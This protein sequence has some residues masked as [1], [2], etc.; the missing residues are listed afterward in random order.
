MI[1]PKKLSE[2][3]QDLRR[4]LAATQDDPIAWLEE[5]VTAAE[6]QGGS[7]AAKTEVLSSI[8]RILE[9]PRRRRKQVGV[10]K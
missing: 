1:G 9:A 4:A 6:H 3:R 2:I 7:Q 8:R 5:R 10:K